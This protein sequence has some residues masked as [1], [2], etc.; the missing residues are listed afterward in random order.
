MKE[1]SF[2]ITCLTGTLLFAGCGETYSD[3]ESY[4]LFLEQSRYWEPNKRHGELFGLKLR[5]DPKS[6]SLPPFFL[7]TCSWEDHAT[8][9]NHELFIGTGCDGNF[10]SFESVKTNEYIEFITI[11]R[12]KQR[13][14]LNDL[15]LRVALIVIDT[16]EVNFQY[17]HWGPQ[18]GVEKLLDSLKN[19]D[20]RFVWSNEIEL[21][22]RNFDVE[23]PGQ[24]W[25]KKTKNPI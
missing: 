19:Q 2:I 9:S 14:E 11:A 22:R 10:M 7:M 18:D 5:L 6:K 21:E 16:M 23:L 1:L 20:H 3:H 8:T 12:A 24:K 15:K 25:L 13:Q 4:S 17:Y